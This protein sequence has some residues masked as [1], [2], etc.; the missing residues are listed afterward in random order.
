VRVSLSKDD[1]GVIII[2]R[3]LSLLVIVS[4][5]VTL[6]LILNSLCTHHDHALQ[7][8]IVDDDAAL[9]HRTLISLIHDSID[10]SREFC[11]LKIWSGIIV[12]LSKK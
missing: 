1:R 2:L 8:V 12:M 5:R 9:S 7:P 4:A 10:S 3:F 11:L 6:I